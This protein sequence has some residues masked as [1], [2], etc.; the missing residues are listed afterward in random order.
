[1]LLRASLAMVLATS[2]FTQFAQAQTVEAA[3]ASFPSKVYQRWAENYEEAH[4]VKVNY[5]PTGSGDGIQKATDR[6]VVFGGTDAPLS[7]DELAKRQLIQM[8]TA[9]GGVVPVVNL[10]VRVQLTGKVLAE[11][12]AGKVSRWNDSRIA[13][14]NPGVS[15]PNLAVQRVVR[16][17]KSGTTEGFTKYLAL[18]NPT[19]N[20]EV[21]FGQL[22]KWP[23]QPLAASGSDGV[24][25]T[26][27]ATE[28]AIGY[29]SFDRVTRNKLNA[30]RLRNA[31]GFWVAAGEAGFRSAVTKSDVFKRGDDL[32]SVLNMPGE[33]S[34]PIT[35]TTYVLFDAVP[36]TAAEADRGLRFIY[37]AFTNGDRMLKGTGFAPLPTNVQAKI[38]TRL[39]GVKPQDGMALSYF[40]L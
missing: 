11:I 37:W 34:W 14:L 10:S 6:K 2:F 9:V 25:E 38:T 30:V 27:E 35:M 32:A 40:R 5:K 8:P 12:F 4:R 16:S 20:A 21:G 13:A 26:L 36:R 3:G 29:V 33:N 24:V 31:D 7:A 22:P 18:M 1:M 19:F 28:G 23:G 39:G 17:D 15:L